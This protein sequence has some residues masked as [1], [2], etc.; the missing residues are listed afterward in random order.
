VGTFSSQYEAKESAAQ[1]ALEE[2][3]NFF[4]DPTK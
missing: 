1:A 4:K 3:V 2:T